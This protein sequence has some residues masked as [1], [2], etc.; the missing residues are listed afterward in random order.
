MNPVPVFNRIYSQGTNSLKFKD[1]VESC[2]LCDIYQ[3]Y[4]FRFIES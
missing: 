4:V 2:A 3:A 1:K